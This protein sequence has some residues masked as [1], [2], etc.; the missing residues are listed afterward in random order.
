MELIKPDRE[1]NQHKFPSESW[2][3]RR[4]LFPSRSHTKDFLIGRNYQEGSPVGHQYTPQQVSL[5]SGSFAKD[6]FISQN[7]KAT[8]THIFWELNMQAQILYQ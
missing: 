5:P 2:K 6:F 8:C 3:K 1:W 7:N 4:K